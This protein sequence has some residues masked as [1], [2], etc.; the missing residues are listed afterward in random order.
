MKGRRGDVSA[1]VLMFPPPPRSQHNAMLLKKLEQLL[2]ISAHRS[3]I[4]RHPLTI[5]LRHCIPIS[6]CEVRTY[7]EDSTTDRHQLRKTLTCITGIALTIMRVMRR[8][9]GPFIATLGV[10]LS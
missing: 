6:Y 10:D 4:Q 5:I 9:K 8:P 1:N 7:L 2:N 3:K